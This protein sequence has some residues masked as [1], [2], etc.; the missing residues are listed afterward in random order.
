MSGT[1]VHPRPVGKPEPDAA[2]G[3]LV[4]ETGFRRM[5]ETIKRETGIDLP[6]SN[7]RSV[8][9]FL[10][11]RCRTLGLD[12]CPYLDYAKANPAEY[13]R[14]IDAVTIK[15]TYFFREEKQFRAMERVVLPRLMASEVRRLSLWSASC[16]TGEEAVSLAALAESAW[17]VSPEYD[18][19]VAASDI[20]A[21]A[22]DA[23]RRGIYTTNA[24]RRDGRRYHVLLSPYLER[25]G[26]RFILK[27]TLRRRVS[28]R[29]LNILRDDLGAF[30]ESFHIVLFRNTLIYMPM[31]VRQ[32]IMD[33]VA[34]TLKPGGHLFLA[35]AEMPLISH[36][37]FSLA[38]YEG[39]YVFR[40]KSPGE[41]GPRAVP[42]P[43]SLGSMRRRRPEPGPDAPGPAP[44]EK[45][46]IEVREILDFAA[47]A[48][49][50]PLFTVEGNI[51]FSLALQ[52]VQVVGLINADRR[53]E[54][55]DLLALIDPVVPANEISL[56]LSGYLEM[57]AGND[58]RARHL[59]TRTLSMDRRF[60][61]ARFHLAMLQRNVS[62]RKAL[63][64]FTA[65]E[66]DIAAYIREDGG[67][68]RLL[69]EGFNAR[70]FL[71]IC[72]KW[73]AKLTPED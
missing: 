46:R 59:F 1:P 56:Y 57:A 50:N 22:L 48:L 2:A 64:T 28:V 38:E 71:E 16:A 5:I 17:A 33:R 26:D 32:A 70:Y 6:G 4:S 41:R 69:L 13:D 35:A 49:D 8:R 61:P 45:H 20:N 10:A 60:W 37:E 7:H 21:R 19:T 25:S 52:F 65:C 27:E 24:F 15:E 30:R 72:R 54:A 66:R 29:R 23:L 3:G 53:Y 36:P 31:E 68:F 63:E 67:A 62:P 43:E 55:R 51:N 18:Y 47:R 12:V 14:L 9:D 34:A 39:V 42:D 44:A 73:I 11:R 40:K 58:G